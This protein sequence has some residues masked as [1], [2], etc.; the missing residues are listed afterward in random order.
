MDVLEQLDFFEKI[1]F[2]TRRLP[3]VILPKGLENILW[4]RNRGETVHKLELSQ[5]WEDTQI[6]TQYQTNIARDVD[7]EKVCWIKWW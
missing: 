5:A 1:N 3:S 4:H 6:D 7:N 2:T